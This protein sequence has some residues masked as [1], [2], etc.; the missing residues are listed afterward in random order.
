MIAITK[1]EIA[2]AETNYCALI[3]VSVPINLL[4]QLA[5]DSQENIV[6]EKRPPSE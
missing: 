6:N 3:K 4:H 5:D 1:N 2:V